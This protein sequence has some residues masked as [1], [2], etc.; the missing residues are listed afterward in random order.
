[1][2]KLIQLVHAV[3]EEM[4]GLSWV[5]LGVLLA[6]SIVLATVALRW[7]RHGG[8]ATGGEFFAQQRE[9]ARWLRNR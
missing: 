3:H 6:V 1:M 2:E 7:I 9:S 4:G 8:L 5:A